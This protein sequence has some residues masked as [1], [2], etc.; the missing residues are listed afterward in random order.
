M[1]NYPGATLP[2]PDLVDTQNQFS[3]QSES[4]RF[5]D[6]TVLF[7]KKEN[8]NTRELIGVALG[9]LHG[10]KSFGI[11]DLAD[12]MRLLITI[13]HLDYKP[14]NQKLYEAAKGIPAHSGGRIGYTFHRG[15]GRSKRGIER[16]VFI[17]LR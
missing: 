9:Y 1:A 12:F 5:R 3:D 2:Y 13:Y 4:E 10:R 14:N 15:K 6:A 16:G 17:F 8:V 11:E 7:C